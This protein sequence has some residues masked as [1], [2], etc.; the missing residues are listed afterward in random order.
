MPLGIGYGKGKKK[1]GTT[2]VVSSVLDYI[3]GK[4]NTTK[5]GSMDDDSV[6]RMRKKRKALENANKS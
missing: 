4:G 2:S 6:K 3:F 1:K 5:P